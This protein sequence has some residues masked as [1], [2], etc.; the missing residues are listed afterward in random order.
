MQIKTAD[1]PC[2]E[3]SAKSSGV[4][5]RIIQTITDSSR[6][7]DGEGIENLL[8]EVEKLLEEA[9]SEGAAKIESFPIKARD[10][11]I[12][13]TV[14][15]HAVDKEAMTVVNG[16]GGDA[17][18][19][20][21][22]APS[23]QVVRQGD[24][25]VAKASGNGKGSENV[26]RVG[27]KKSTVRDADSEIPH[28]DGEDHG[29]FDHFHSLL[30]KEQEKLELEQR[31]LELESLG[32]KL[33]SRMIVLEKHTLELEA[34]RFELFE[35]ELGS[36]G[37]DG[38]GADGEILDE[39]EEDHGE[40]HLLLKE[41]RMRELET[42]EMGLERRRLE[43]DL[44]EIALEKKNLELELKRNELLRKELENPER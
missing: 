41:Q 25:K 13:L 33:E 12:Q 40:P 24:K 31:K 29:I 21:V 38:E 5:K 34:M 22:T 27:I 32:I 35:E 18:T 28:E 17:K 37:P 1:T 2:P 39:G 7:L 10:G 6:V 9:K 19:M 26:F 4:G 23:G 43:L 14:V 42:R 16:S 36:R 44:R 11:D 30:M 20:T 3:C 15:G 8:E